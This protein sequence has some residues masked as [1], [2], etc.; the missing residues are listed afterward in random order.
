MRSKYSASLEAAK[1][2]PAD[3][4]AAAKLK[5]LANAAR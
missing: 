1:I 2:S 4:E 3:P 5:A